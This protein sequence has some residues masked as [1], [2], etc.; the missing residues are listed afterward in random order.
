MKN[1]GTAAVETGHCGGDDG[2]VG[3]LLRVAENL[4]KTCYRSAVEH[5]VDIC[6]NHAAAVGIASTVVAYIG[7]NADVVEKETV[8]MVSGEGTDFRLML[9]IPQ[10]CHAGMREKETVVT[11]LRLKGQLE[12]GQM[13][14]EEVGVTRGVVVVVAGAH[15]QIAI[16]LIHIM[17][18]VI[19][20]QKNDLIGVFFLEGNDGPEV[21]KGFMEGDF[22]PGIRVEIVAQEDDLPVIF[23]VG[24]SCL[25]EVTSV[26]V[27]ED[28]NVVVL[29][30]RFTV[31]NGLRL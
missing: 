27:G 29:H 14:M 13:G 12:Q 11:I 2:I 22:F 15:G 17:K 28:E 18:V 23:R 10:L 24:D 3:V 5:L 8:E 21:F 9:I 20:E 4:I 25:P 30:I 26:D 7:K 1:E 19:A 6:P 31:R 16:N